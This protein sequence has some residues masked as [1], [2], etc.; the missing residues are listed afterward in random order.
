MARRLS[1]RVAEGGQEVG[2]RRLGKFL[3]V[4]GGRGHPK[5]DYLSPE[6][7][8]DQSQH[9]GESGVFFSI[10]GRPAGVQLTG[11]TAAVKV[12]SPGVVSLAGAGPTGQ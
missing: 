10:L 5:R 11:K 2:R 8:A 1:G 6:G 3:D 7:V 9:I 12:G 4:G